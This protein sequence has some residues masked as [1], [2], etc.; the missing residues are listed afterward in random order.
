MII[1]CWIVLTVCFGIKLLGGNF[2]SIVVSNEIYQAICG[3]VNKCIWTQIIIGSISTILLNTLFLLAINRKLK[4]TAL[5]TIIIVVFSI[6]SVTLRTCTDCAPLD[7]ILNCI[8]YFVLPFIVKSEY[9]MKRKIVYTIVGNIL[10]L[11]FQIVSLI[12]KNLALGYVTL[13]VVSGFIWM[14]DIYI[15]TVLYYLYANFNKGGYTMGWFADWLWNK[16]ED[17]L[18][19]MK[20]TRL[21]RIDKINKEI[22]AIDAEIAKKKNED[23]K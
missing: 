15:M 22:V 1:L 7:L 4:L 20:E 14:I 5:E 3:Y 19:K 11:V 23:K 12:T 2:F 8:Q 10:V 9:T 13:D 16:S 6:G 21:K 17:Q 18:K